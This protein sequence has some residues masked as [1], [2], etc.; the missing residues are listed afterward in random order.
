MTIGKIVDIGLP[1]PVW[2]RAVEIDGFIII[3]DWDDYPIGG[4]PIE[5][6]PLSERGIKCIKEI[7][8]KIENELFS[9]IFGY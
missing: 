4:F 3:E 6:L 2:A 7:I 5:L 8:E 9:K 1:L